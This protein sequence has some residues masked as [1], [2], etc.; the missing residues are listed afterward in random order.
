MAYGQI[1]RPERA[2]KHERAGEW[3]EHLSGE[4][5]DKAELLAHHFTTALALRQPHTELLRYIDAPSLRPWLERSSSL[6]SLG[7]KATPSGV[8]RL[9]APR[10][11]RAISETT[12]APR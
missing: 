2:A 6:D 10:L 5:D 3:I 9:L 1:R 12:P 4:R 8:W 7:I 11:Q